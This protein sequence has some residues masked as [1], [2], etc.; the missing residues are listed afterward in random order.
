M[1]TVCIQICVHE[2]SQST[3][4][5]DQHAEV[6]AVLSSRAQACIYIP[7]DIP[8]IELK[9]HVQD[10]NLFS[11][12]QPKPPQ[13]LIIQRLCQLCHKIH[14]QAPRFPI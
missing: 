5:P 10:L 11:H 12:L 1:Q 13:V 14:L 7:L 3:M 8:L 6:A 2:S 4:R 9:P